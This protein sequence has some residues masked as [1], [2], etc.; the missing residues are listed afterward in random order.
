M[1]SI[2]F[3]RPTHVG[4]YNVITYPRRPRCVKVIAYPLFAGSVLRPGRFKPI[5]VLLA[6]G[7]K[8]LDG[9]FA[10]PPL[11]PESSDCAIINNSNGIG[12]I[13]TLRGCTFRQTR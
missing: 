7:N 12:Y 3:R 1:C 6:G 10:K 8:L 4:V 11:A 5:V 2:H 13:S 9:R